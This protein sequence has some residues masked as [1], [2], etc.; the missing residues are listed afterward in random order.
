MKPTPNRKKDLEYWSNWLCCDN[1]PWYRSDGTMYPPSLKMAP[2]IHSL[3]VKT[4]RVSTCPQ[5][6]SKKTHLS[7]ACPIW[8]SCSTQRAF[9]AWTSFLWQ[10]YPFLCT[11]TQWSAATIVS[12]FPELGNFL[13]HVQFIASRPPDETIA[14]T[15]KVGFGVKAVMHL[16]EREHIILHPCAYVAAAERDDVLSLK[17]LHQRGCPWHEKTIATAI[18]RGSL[19]CLQYAY[20]YMRDGAL[21]LECMKMAADAGQIPAMQFLHKIGIPYDKLIYTTVANLAVVK[22]LRGIG[23][24]WVSHHCSHFVTRNLL[25][26]VIFANSNGSRWSVHT[27]QAAALN[28]R[29][30]ILQY[31]H[32]HGCP[33]DAQVTYNAA[34]KGHAMCLKYAL[35]RRCPCTWRTLYCAG[36]ERKWACIVLLIRHRFARLVTALVIAMICF[37]FAVYWGG[38]IVLDFVCDAYHIVLL[39]VRFLRNE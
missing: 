20:A 23:C 38:P 24:A 1:C 5:T 21:P 18:I 29:L 32:T 37:C 17:Y 4:K 31:L 3:I 35:L 14:A 7:R 26:C 10:L 11:K 30:K 27:T 34:Q 28:G 22:H 15:I 33:W 39:T 9:G 19:R 12:T 6:A 36:K 13:K 25:D 2:Y 16:H 8:R